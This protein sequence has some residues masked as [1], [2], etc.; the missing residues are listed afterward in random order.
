MQNLND[1]RTRVP[2][3][4]VGIDIAINQGGLHW[5]PVILTFFS[6]EMP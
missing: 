2:A 6:N 1:R 5:S 3:G 4:S